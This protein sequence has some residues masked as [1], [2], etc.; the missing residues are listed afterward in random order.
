MFRSCALISLSLAETFTVKTDGTGDSYQPV[1]S[2]PIDLEHALL[3]VTS[4][5]NNH[6]ALVSTSGTESEVVYEIILGRT[7]DSAIII[8][9]S[10][11]DQANEM[12]D[13]EFQ[14]LIH[15][16]FSPTSF[17]YP[18]PTSIYPSHSSILT[19]DF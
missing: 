5:C 1:N 2:D 19:A 11:S 9:P 18:P 14:V 13:K 6:I 15:S 8:H 4:G 7:S 17:F 12:T 3:E 10:P 16:S